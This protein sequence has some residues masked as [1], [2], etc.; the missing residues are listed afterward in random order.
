MGDA[1][2]TQVVQELV[3]GAPDARITQVIQELV[4]GAPSAAVTQVAVLGVKAHRTDELVCT[5]VVS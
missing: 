1:N 3:G 5:I 4:G 2:V